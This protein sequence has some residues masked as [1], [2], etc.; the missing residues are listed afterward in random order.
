MSLAQNGSTP[1]LDSLA[2]HVNIP[3]AFVQT[4]SI[5]WHWFV[6]RL[7][8]DL[9]TLWN[10]NKP[11]NKLDN[12]YIDFFFLNLFEWKKFNKCSKWKAGR[13][14]WRSPI[15]I[16][17]KVRDQNNRHCTASWSKLESITLPWWNFFDSSLNFHFL[18]LN[19][20]HLSG[21]F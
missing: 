19:S 12:K 5:T 13:L 1:G 21:S 7:W 2:L 17:T 9:I 14:S 11:L 3:E 20:V 16:Q 15:Q 18:S 4:E 10:T 8:S 6:T